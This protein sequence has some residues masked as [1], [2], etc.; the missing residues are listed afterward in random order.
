MLGGFGLGL[1]C[2]VADT[3]LTVNVGNRGND[4]LA[5]EHSFFLGS[6]GVLEGLTV[7]TA[8]KGTF[9]AEIFDLA[10]LD[11]ADVVAKVLYVCGD[12]S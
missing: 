1:V 3:G 2:N 5:A 12:V 8:N 11:N 7:D 10:L 4:G 9:L 6:A